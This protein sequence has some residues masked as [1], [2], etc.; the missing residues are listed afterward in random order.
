M[1]EASRGGCGDGGWE[2]GRDAPAAAADD[3][4]AVL[5]ARARALARRESAGTADERSIEALSFLL[6]D[7]TYAIETPFIREVYPL[8]ELTP[9]PC[10]PDF[11]RGIINV[12]GRIL[13]VVDIRGFFDLPG[14]GMTDLDR[15]IIL[16]AGAMEL[17]ILADEIIGIGDIPGGDLHPPPPGASA[18]RMGYFKGVAADGRILLDVEELLADPRLVV[19]EEVEA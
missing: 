9:V 16:H 14:K 13:T 12:R 4:G 10:T 11:I 17:G 6:A 1:N 3:V 7:E 2:P 15:V 5:R 8:T 18:T 19:Q